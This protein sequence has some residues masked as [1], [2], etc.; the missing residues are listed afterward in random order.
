MLCKFEK[1]ETATKEKT[2]AKSR[3]I[4]KLCQNLT[5]YGMTVKHDYMF[6]GNCGKTSYRLQRIHPTRLLRL[7]S[8]SS[9]RLDCPNGVSFD[10]GVLLSEVPCKEKCSGKKF[11]DEVQNNNL[12][13]YS[14]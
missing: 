3:V 6:F 8:G 11:S 2:L 12:K 14:F 5:S 13:Q 1:T 7:F 4:A 10:Q 9:V